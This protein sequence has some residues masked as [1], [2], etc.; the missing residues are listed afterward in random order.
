MS[1]PHLLGHGDGVARSYAASASVPG[2][3]FPCGQVPTRP[4]GTT[5][6]DIGEQ[7]TVCLDN[8]ERT[9]QAAG[10]GLDRLLQVTVYLADLDEFDAYD[11]AYRA[12]LQPH[13]LP[14]RTTVQ[15]ARFRGSKRVELV[16]VAAGPDDPSGQAPSPANRTVQHAGPGSG[17][18]ASSSTSITTEEVAR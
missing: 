3:V 12:R 1:V 14:P 10:S 16:A 4:D 18:S 7:V 15:V 8:L 17:T 11:A 9:L 2:L 13:P 6:A 5:P